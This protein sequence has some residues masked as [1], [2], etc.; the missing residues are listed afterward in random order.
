MKVSSML[1]LVCI[2]LVVMAACGDDD[3]SS[4]GEG[5][6]KKEVAIG[7]FDIGPNSFQEASI[8]EAKRIARDD[9]NATVEVM[10][11]D[12][13][14]TKQ[15]NQIQD[16][17]AAKKFDA[18]VISP[19]NSVGVAPV[20]KQAEDAGIPVIA[21]NTPI[22]PSL[23]TAEPQVP[24][25]V[26]SVVVPT[27]EIARNIALMA[28]DACEG[29]D[30]CKI[31]LIGATGSTA[32]DRAAIENIERVAEESPNISHVATGG[33]N[34]LRDPAV[35]LTRDFLQK[36]PDLS[37]IATI[38]DQPAVGAMI[39]AK[40]AGKLED[41]KIIGAGAGVTA[42]RLIRAGDLYGTAISLPIDQGRYAMEM[43]IKA[44]R[45]QD[46]GR[47]AINAV[48]ESGLPPYMTR[49]NLSKFEDF[50]P[51]WDG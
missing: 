50:E 13:D 49:D 1:S 27:T 22:G 47:R 23:D 2:A 35:G 31:A 8:E 9:G 37:V 20:A 21:E 11:P 26:G 46:I 28:R 18:I 39:A 29:I 36:D 12:F 3:S 17:I 44:A 5:N 14:A 34:F 10:N 24:G 40:D 6:G 42:V 19:L 16:A 45:G 43:A 25:V 33:A 41:I 7:W 51:Q 48:E 38:G 15:I 30:P 32:F 4:G